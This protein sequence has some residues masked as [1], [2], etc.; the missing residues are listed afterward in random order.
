M[1]SFTA[2]K[3]NLMFSVSMA[4][5]KW[6]KRAFD[7][8]LLLLSNICKIKFCTSSILWG[9]PWKAGKKSFILVYLIFSK[10]RSVLFRNRMIDTLAKNLLLTIVSKILHDSTSRFVVLS[11]IRTWSNA[12]EDTKKRIDVTSSKHWNH[13]ALCDLCPPTSTILNGIPLIMN[14]C[15]TMPF[16]ALRAWSASCLVGTK[17]WKK[18]VKKILTNGQVFSKI[19]YFSEHQWK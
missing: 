15:S 17:S 13:L 8:S 14:S 3:T 9:S 11:S 10:S 2:W 16:V 1:V 12:L 6:W 4:V 19:L 18:K 7:L 5:V